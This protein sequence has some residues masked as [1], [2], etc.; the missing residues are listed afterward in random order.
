VNLVSLMFMLP[1]ALGNAACTLVS[2]RLGA[3][4]SRDARRLSWHGVVFGLALATLTGGSVYLARES[5]LRAYTADTAIIAAALP[6]LAWVML[7]HMA[8]AAQ[9]LAAFT[10]R[11]YQLTLAPML[12]YAAALWGVGLAG[13]YALGLDTTGLTPPA[14]LGAPG[15]WAACTAGV[16]LAALALCALLGWVLHTRRREERRE[17]RRLHAATAG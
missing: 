14:L 15:F 11:A 4:D 6:L 8:D 12:I 2:Q 5:L 3:G 10:L 17:R 1:L 13:G 16:T 9:T 7:F